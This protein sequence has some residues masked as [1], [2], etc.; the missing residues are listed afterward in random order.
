MS[1]AANVPQIKML[2]D[3]MVSPFVRR[4]DVYRRPV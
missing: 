2:F 4:T 3:F 1:A